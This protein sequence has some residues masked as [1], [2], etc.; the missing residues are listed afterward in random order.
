MESRLIRILLE[1]PEDPLK[2]PPTTLALH[3]KKSNSSTCQE[4]K[5]IFQHPLTQKIQVGS[6]EK[7]TLQKCTPCSHQQKYPVKIFCCVFK[8]ALI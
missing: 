2:S 1:K 3:E 6:V 4:T 5:L 7:V 8:L